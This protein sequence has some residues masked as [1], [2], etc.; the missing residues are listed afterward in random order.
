MTSHLDGVEEA[1]HVRIVYAL[2]LSRR[3]P[4]K[5]RVFDIAGTP[6]VTLTRIEPLRGRGA[7]R[8]GLLRRASR[9]GFVQLWDESA[10]TPPRWRAP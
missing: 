6:A 7:V 8:A 2:E 4:R 1:P 10:G 3:A 9:N 5:T